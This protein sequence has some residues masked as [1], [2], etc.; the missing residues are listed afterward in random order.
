[1]ANTLTNLIPAIVKGFDVVS[2]ELVGF[3]PSVNRDPSAD[4]IAK[5]QTLYSWQ[6][7]TASLSDITPA[8]VSPQA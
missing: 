2:R 8:N 4:R 3:I 7:P 6:A 5:N 1:M